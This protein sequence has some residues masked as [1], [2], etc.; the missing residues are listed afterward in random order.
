MFSLRVGKESALCER[1]SPSS[2]L[3]ERRPDKAW[4]IESSPVTSKDQMNMEE[5]NSEKGPGP[6]PSLPSGRTLLYTAQSKSHLSFVSPP[7]P[8]PPPTPDSVTSAYSLPPSALWTWNCRCP[9]L[10]E[11]GRKC[12]VPVNFLLYTFSSTNV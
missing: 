1:R 2:R 7:R 5:M 3:S 11:E 12:L 8:P 10:Y 9:A 4:R 6:L